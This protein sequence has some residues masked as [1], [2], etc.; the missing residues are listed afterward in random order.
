ML[1]RATAALPNPERDRRITALTATLGLFGWR[2]D[3]APSTLG[4]IMNRTPDLNGADFNDALGTPITVLRRATAQNAA[5][6]RQRADTERVA[7]FRAE[8]VPRP[9]E[10]LAKLSGLWQPFRKSVDAT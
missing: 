9:N 7:N 5:A 1:P 4:L 10:V 3:T 8:A 6:R 2:A